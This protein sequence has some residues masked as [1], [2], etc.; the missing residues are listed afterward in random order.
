LARTCRIAPPSLPPKWVMVRA[1]LRLWFSQPAS[2]CFH[3]R[4]L[5]NGFY[6]EIRQGCCRRSLRRGN[7][8]AES[9]P[10]RR[11]SY[12]SK[13]RERIR[14]QLSPVEP[15]ESSEQFSLVTKRLVIGHV[16][17]C[18]GCCC[19]NAANGIPLVPVDWCNQQPA[20]YSL[21][22]V[23]SPLNS[24]LPSAAEHVLSTR[25]SRSRFSYLVRQELDT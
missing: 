9:S 21:R 8:L 19:G 24:G 2:H 15:H 13:R 5:G 16:T 6:S 23:R 10:N 1:A 14:Q 20:L 4:F 22:Y 11:R 3:P 25:K 7:S 12:T 17:I 18:H